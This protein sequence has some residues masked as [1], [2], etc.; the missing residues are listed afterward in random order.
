V[1]TGLLFYDP[2]VGASRVTVGLTAAVH[3]LASRWWESG[4]TEAV[5]VETVPGTERP[6]LSYCAQVSDVV[7]DPETG[8]VL[9]SSVVTAADVSSVLRPRSHRM[10]IDGGTIMGYG[11]ACLEDLLERDGQVWA[12][13]L[14]ELRLPTAADV[15]SLRTVLVDGGRGVGPANVEAV[16]E[17]TN[18]PTAAAI[19]NAV[20]EATGRRVRQL[21]LT[22]ER[23]FWALHGETGGETRDEA[24]SVARDGAC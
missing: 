13:N 2:G 10:Q 23:V 8:Q 15:L 16:G 12:P 18:V 17:L 19:A 22:A 11:F 3:Q 20:A 7:V 5:T 6:A 21:P 14:A 4:G 9:V 1:S 24:R